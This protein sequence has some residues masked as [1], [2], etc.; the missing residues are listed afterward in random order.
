MDKAAVES[1]STILVC[2]GGE[3]VTEVRL[4]K[5]ESVLLTRIGFNGEIY[6]FHTK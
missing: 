1:S 4:F 3:A 6:T 2:C 5:E